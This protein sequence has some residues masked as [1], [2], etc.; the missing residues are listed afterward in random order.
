MAAP[1]CMMLLLKG[2][3]QQWKNFLQLVPQWQQLTGKAAPR[4]MTLLP[5]GGQQQ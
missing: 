3:Q 4:C 5:W 2:R 1:R